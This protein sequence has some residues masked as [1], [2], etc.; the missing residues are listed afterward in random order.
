MAGS[1]SLRY[2]YCLQHPPEIHALEVWAEIVRQALVLQNHGTRERDSIFMAVHRA[3]G[4]GPP[5][6][7]K[8]SLC[9]GIDILI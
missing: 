9:G 8:K 4:C 2:L 1:K 3:M 6:P 7:K 5:P